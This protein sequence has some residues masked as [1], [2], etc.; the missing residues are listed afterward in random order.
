MSSRKHADRSEAA[1]KRRAGLSV[2]STLLI[3]LLVVS[4]LSSIVVGL[5]G[6]VNGS[7]SLRDAAFDR[8][9]G[10]RDSRAREITSLFES[11]KNAVLL[12][13]RSADAIEAT[14][15]FAAAFAELADEEISEEDQNAIKSYF[16][17]P[18]AD[19]MAEEV[20]HSVD[21]SS[22]MP[23][24]AAE[25]YLQLHYTI[26][27]ED[28]TK[29]IETVDAGDGSTWSEVHS[30]FHEQFR[31]VTE[32]LNLED[33]LLIDTQGNVIYSAYKGVDL[34]TNLLT[35]PYA[36]GNLAT[37]Y[38]K[39]MG[40]N[41]L[42]SIEFTDFGDYPPSVDK[43][44]AWAVSP[45]GSDGQ[46]VG[47]I[48]VELP[49]D[50]IN[51]VMTGDFEWSAK[52]LGKTGETY[53][54]GEDRYMRSSSREAI[55]DPQGYAKLAVK[56]GLDAETASRI[57]ETGDT[58][59]EQ[60][61]DT[62][63]VN[64]AFAG[65]KGTVVGPNYLG[66]DSMAAFSPLKVEGLNW[67]IVAEIGSSEAFAPVQTFN[68][69]LF[70]STAALIVFVS[71]LSLL[72]AQI[73]VRPLKRLKVAAGKIAAGEEGVLVDAGRSDELA[74]VGAAFNDMSKALQVKANLLDDQIAENERLLLTL[75]PQQVAK[76]F[77]DGDQNI[78][79]DH[80]EVSVIYAEIMGFD[81]YSRNLS[82]DA[83]LDKLNEILKNFDEAADRHGVERV[84]TTRD[85]Y[86]ACCGLTVPRVDNAR[87]IVEFA[88]ELQQ[89]LDRFG[90][91]LG[92]PLS[93]RA[94]IDNGMV[95]SGLIG[96]TRLVYDLW[97]DAV[98]LALRL[99]Q[100]SRDPGI[101]LT[102]NVKNQLPVGHPTTPSGVIE[103]GG[104]VQQVWRIDLSSSNG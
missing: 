88:I 46:A 36:L 13:S 23:S 25:S 9:V 81:V 11:V 32:L 3:M 16:S 102:Q 44:A 73:I 80:Q 42:D 28:F 34:G 2:Q 47:A 15:E 87:R 56:A 70:F 77:R 59:L 68:K 96:R 20:G 103:T 58:L 69:N 94:G 17:G 7:D 85:G 104:S 98:S 71:L 53:L 51:S 89:I 21:T 74:D 90:R 33:L 8:L 95:S 27:F 79:E 93:L 19:R 49:I 14:T 62:S 66:V 78:V 82:S 26:P 52:G 97:G 101:L 29:S 75:M 38:R 99:R 48:A 63:A 35:G 65:E 30:R 22:F 31:R 64:Q 55:E 10:V 100:N 76:R 61:V 91:Q 41:L 39:T 84:R 57:A 92:T 6:Y 40:A 54:V 72:L 43:P 45:V 67:V 12:E 24:S 1:P 60:R 83:A 50:S 18:F 4:L 5:I 37:A 86:L